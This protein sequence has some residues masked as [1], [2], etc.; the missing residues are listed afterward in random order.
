MGILTVFA[1]E[2]GLEAIGRVVSRLLGEPNAPVDQDTVVPTGLNALDERLAGGLRTGQTT[3]VAARSGDGASTF[4]LA[5]ARSAALHHH[6]PTLVTAPDAPESEV[7]M[8]LIS[9]ETN[10]PLQRLRGRALNEREVQRVRERE[11]RIT[12]EHLSIVAGSPLAGTLVDSIVAM[13]HGDDVRVVIVDSI[14]TLG[15]SAREDVASMAAWAREHHFAL[16][17]VTGALHP[18]TGE[19][20]PLQLA[21]LRDYDAIA[22]LVDVVLVIERAEPPEAVIHVVKHRY[23]PTGSIRVGHIAHCCSYANLP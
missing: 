11:E 17:L 13:T 14:A 16:V 21:D 19:E 22:D 2:L 5:L 4:A 18:T 23:G 20:R 9:A 12:S 6:L 8:R 7:V 1:M 3:V 15:A 10:I